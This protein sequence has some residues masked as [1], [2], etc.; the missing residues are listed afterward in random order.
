M[1]NNIEKKTVTQRPQRNGFRDFVLLAGPWTIKFGEKEKP[2]SIHVPSSWNEVFPDKRDHLGPAVYTAAFR[3]PKAWKSGRIFLQFGSVNYYSQV[4]VNGR[5]LGSHE[6]GQLPFEFEV[7]RGILK[8]KNILSVQVEGLLS[9]DRVPPGKVT[10]DPRDAFAHTQYPAASFDFFPFCGIHRNVYLHCVP[11][12]SIGDITVTTSISGKDGAVRVDLEKDFTGAAKAKFTISLKGGETDS[13]HLTRT[14]VFSGKRASVVFS[15]PGA[16]FW[17]PGSP[18][19]Y[20]L[21]ADLFSGGIQSDRY[22]LDFGIRTF[23]S[24]GGSLYLNNKKI[25]LKGFGRH[26]DFP[27]TGRG[28]SPRW[29]AKDFQLLKRTGA[30]S[31]RTSHYPYAEEQMDLA[32]R[33][34][35]IVIDETPAVGLFFSAPGF[36]K[37]EEL[38]RQYIREMI[39]RDKNHACV[40]MWSL[41]NEP[42]SSRP[43]AVPFFKRLAV[44]ARSLDRIRPITIA[45][46]R[47]AD[48]ASFDFLDVVCVNR[49]LGWYSE[50]GRLDIALPKLSK[51]LDQ[52]YKTFKK[53]V[54]VSEFGADA[55]PGNRQLKNPEMFTEDYQKDM[56]EGYLKVISKKPYAAGA[57]VWNLCDFKTGQGVHRPGGMNWK[58]IFTRK[59]KPKLA[60]K[61]IRKMWKLL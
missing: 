23:C 56:I 7:E 37:R 43:A 15:V 10:Y 21:K 24:R 11:Q 22:Q 49:Y 17:S 61:M 20:T 52:I 47:G 41:A 45:S 50:M 46:Y 3:V 30:N 42:H 40:V 33:L 4:S 55:F 26:E 13:T 12:E 25:F 38:C 18:S 19:L 59:R 35:F 16:K 28:Y 60:A 2:R 48:E 5:P 36:N 31:F 51:D 58:G 9:A 53:P 34:G 27:G 54:I 44:L 8:K 39:M 57:H 32:D 14:A 1:A 6:G 29:A